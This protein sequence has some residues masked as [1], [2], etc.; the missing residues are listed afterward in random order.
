M[1]DLKRAVSAELAKA[2]GVE[3]EVI[4]NWK[5]TTQASPGAVHD[6]LADWYAGRIYLLVPKNVYDKLRGKK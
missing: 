3:D 1:T 2:M 5:K 6:I 4:D